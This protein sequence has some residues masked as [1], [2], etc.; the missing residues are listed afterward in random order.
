MR[1][2]LA[3]FLSVSFLNLS[4]TPPEL[5][6]KVKKELKKHFDSESFVMSEIKNLSND[7]E[8][9]FELSDQG[10]NLGIV[11]LTTARGRYDKFDYMIIYNPDLEIEL[12]KILVYRS[13]YG[14]EI[15]AR[16]WLS[17]FY[18]EQEDDSLKYGSDIQAISGATFSG[19]AI[20]KNI[21][22]INKV[23][24]EYKQN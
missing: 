16:R 2:L 1:I 6:K 18:G 12:I 4:A 22:R 24:K 17:Q 11:V 15:S 21:I 7:D 23:L 13:Q 19:M 20:T 5:S 14:S 3:L 8:I 9:Y 10:K